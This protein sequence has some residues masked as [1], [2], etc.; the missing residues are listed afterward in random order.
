MSGGTGTMRCRH[1]RGTGTRGCRHKGDMCWVVGSG[2]SAT[3][4]HRQAEGG[5]VVVGTSGRG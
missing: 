3:R 2:G 1:C 4:A 5:Q